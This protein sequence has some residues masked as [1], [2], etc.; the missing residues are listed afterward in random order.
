MIAPAEDRFSM[1]RVL[2]DV[3]FQADEST[4]QSPIDTDGLKNLIVSKVLAHTQQSAGGNSERVLDPG[5][6]SW[7]LD[8]AGTEGAS[9]PEP[10]PYPNPDWHRRGL[11]PLI[12][13]PY[14]H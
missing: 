9:V 10:R 7:R 14:Y 2:D 13:I 4:L 1:D 12:R 3:W 11:R 8:R 5:A 6:G